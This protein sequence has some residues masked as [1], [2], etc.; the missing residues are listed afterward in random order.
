MAA[1]IS[2]GFVFG[3]QGTEPLQEAIR[4]AVFRH[5]PHGIVS[6][7]QQEVRPGLIESLLQPGQLAVGV[8]RPQG[9]PGLLVQEVVRVATQHD[10]VEHDDGQGLARVGNVEVQLVVVGWELPVDQTRV[11]TLSLWF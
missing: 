11:A 5:R 3:E 2:C 9:T 6:R 1:E 10:G 7:H 4:G 8:H